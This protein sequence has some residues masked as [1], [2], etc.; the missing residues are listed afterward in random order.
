MQK[1]YFYSPLNVYYC[2]YANYIYSFSYFQPLSGNK[3]LADALQIP[4]D[5]KTLKKF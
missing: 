5:R 2:F 4:K 3:K 1:K